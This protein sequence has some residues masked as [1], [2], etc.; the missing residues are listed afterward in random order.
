MISR[1][2][3]LLG[4]VLVGRGSRRGA[5]AL[6]IAILLLSGLTCGGGTPS[7][8]ATPTTAVHP[9]PTPSASVFDTGRT[10][11]GFTPSSPEIT[12]ESFTAT[13]QA[14]RQHGDVILTMPQVPWAEFIHQS[15][16][17]SPTIDEMRN[18]LDFA[19]QYGL[20]T[21]FVIDPLQSFD[22][23]KIATFPPELAGGNFGTPAVRQAFKNFALRLV[24]EFQPRYLGL[25]SE[26]N[27]YADAEPE[28]FAHY[29]SLYH[30]A[31]AAVKAEAPETQIFVTF[32]W[33]DL[34]SLGPFSDDEPGRVKW[35]IVESFEPELDLWAIST[36][37]YFAFD[38]AT[39]IPADYY[40]SLL[41]R[42]S[43]PLAVAE[44]GYLSQDAGPFHG[45]PQGQVGYLEALNA[46]IGERL[47]F[48][49]YLVIDDFD[50]E[51]YAR[52]LTEH[53]SPA[54]VE[55]VELFGSLGLRS[56]DGEPKP[57]MEVWD[58]LRR[59]E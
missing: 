13:L 54:D 4:R 1:Y 33:E 24:R 14:I 32:Q 34:N 51:A 48:W 19:R 55:T 6:G 31:Y 46:Q 11:F 37:P 50:I 27:T 44:G 5:L 22:R 59:G 40:T 41:S 16:G 20:E 9:S 28:D 2:G 45:S 53:G 57:A 30:E 15:D 10:A 52:H 7:P 43:K 21:I 3:C 17:D 29:L 26:I 18:T 8:T 39:Q 49:I 23:R 56:K 42:T 36:Y 35:E 12:A 58:R 38:D 25:A 47:A